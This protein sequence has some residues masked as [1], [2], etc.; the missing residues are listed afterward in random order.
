MGKIEIPVHLIN[1]KTERDQ[2]SLFAFLISHLIQWAFSQ[3]YEITCGDFYDTDNDG[4]HM[5]GSVHGNRMAADLNLFKGGKYLVDS[6]EHKPIGDYWKTLHPLCRHG[7]DFKKPDG[8][9]YSL[10]WLGKA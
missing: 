7:G 10:T 8:N 4:G 9:H 2:Q 1:P 3:G 5:K 6:K